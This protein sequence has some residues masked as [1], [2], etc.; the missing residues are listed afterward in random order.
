MAPAAL[1]PRGLRSDRPAP[2]AGAASSSAAA[3]WPRPRFRALAIKSPRQ[4][5]QGVLIRVQGDQIDDVQTRR[6]NQ[7]GL[8]ESA[9]W[10]GRPRRRRARRSASPEASVR[11]GSD[12][13]Q[14]RV[15]GLRSASRRSS[16]ASR[17]QK[18]PYADA[19]DRSR[20]T[21]DAQPEG[22]RSRRPNTL[23][24]ISRSPSRVAVSA[25][26]RPS[27]VRSTRPW[28]QASRSVVQDSFRSCVCSGQGF[29]PNSPYRG[30]E[31]A[32]AL[33]V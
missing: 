15:A 14:R 16:L 21:V 1:A 8:G 24:F 17:V 22:S 2:P 7:A 33:K 30:A 25:E 31:R 18:S 13:R 5:G 12:R 23:A 9:P 32:L 29:R 26:M 28:A 6:F 10:P 20:R 4:Q 3:P 11:S 27:R 19:S